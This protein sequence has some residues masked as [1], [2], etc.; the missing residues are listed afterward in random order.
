MANKKNNDEI[1]DALEGSVSN[2][3]KKNISSE[4]LKALQL[5]LDKLEKT[6]GKGTIMKL[7]DSQIEHMEAISTGSLGL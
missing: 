4:K 2:S 7:G 1:L 6:Y 5:T 3:N